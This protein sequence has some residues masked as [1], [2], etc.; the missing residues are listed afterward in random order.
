RVV[1][2]RGDDPHAGDHYPFHAFAALC[3]TADDSGI[4]EQPDAKVL[5]FVNELAVGFHE[6]FGDTEGNLRTNH[7][8]DVDA[9]L[10]ELDVVGD[11]AAELDF[12]AAPRPA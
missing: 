3:L 7:A 9:V 4:L 11:L 12:A 2:D 6:A 1:A 10:D 5:G 8:L